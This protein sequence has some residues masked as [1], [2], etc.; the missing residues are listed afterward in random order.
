M[1]SRHTA[2]EKSRIRRRV[3]DTVKRTI[4]EYEMVVSGTALLVGVSGGPD[5]VAL[6]H[7]LQHLAPEY[8]LRLAVAHLNHGLRKEADDEA[9][10]VAT[11]S[12][13]LGL[14]CH[15]KKDDVSRYRHRHRLSL[16][17]AARLRRYAFYDD[18]ATRHHFDKIALGHQADDNAELVLMFLIRGSGPAGFAGIP[19]VRAERIIRPLIR[20]SRRDILDY[21]KAVGLAY[22]T[23]RTNRDMRFLRNRIRGHLVPLLRRSYNPKISEALNR[24]ADIQREEQAWIKEIADTLYRDARLTDDAHRRHLSI[25]QL[26]RQPKAAQRRIIRKAIIDIKG[27]LR[28]ISFAHVGAAVDL[29]S[30][31]RRDGMLDLPDGIVLE[32]IGNVLRVSKRSGPARPKPGAVEEIYPVTYC[33][34]VKKPNEVAVILTVE[35][36]D[37]QVTFSTVAAGASANLRQTGQQVAFFDIDSLIFPLTLRNVRA[38]DRFRPFG[39]QGTQ[40]IKKYFID[41]K[42]PKEKRRACPVLLSGGCIIWLVG[43]RM[44]EDC[45]VTPATREILRAEITCLTGDRD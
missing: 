43:H 16:E 31:D 42:V 6:L 20:L 15:I 7:I 14:A 45:R 33:Y 4:A 12:A 44:A 17:E 18:V 8:G 37:Y 27:D 22:V 41:H 1:T 30:V 10:F 25:A 21:L 2:P 5:S 32:R 24:L 40:K 38:G 19:P 3:L 23:D 36:I 9:E 35:E 13:G 28:R 39:L 29:L 26:V 11:I 34:G